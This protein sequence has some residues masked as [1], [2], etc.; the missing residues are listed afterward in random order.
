MNALIGMRCV[1]FVV[2]LV[3]A[4]CGP[5]PGTEQQARFTH[6]VFDSA[7]AKWDYFDQPVGFGIS[8]SAAQTSMAMACPTSW[9]RPWTIANTCTSGGTVIRG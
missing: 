4:S 5:R 6:I 7:R 1:C 8:A 9:A 3:P 2:L